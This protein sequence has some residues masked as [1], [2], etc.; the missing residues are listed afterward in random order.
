[1][2]RVYEDYFTPNSKI[3]SRSV[4]IF[5]VFALNTIL[6]LLLTY[7][8]HL[9]GKMSKLMVENLNLL[10]KMHEGLIVVS[11]KDKIVKFAS[12]PAINLLKQMPLTNYT[13][14][15]QRVDMKLDPADLDKPQF[16]LINDTVDT[17]SLK[18]KDEPNHEEISLN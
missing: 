14:D 3:I 10:N 9:R 15:G 17:N 2:P 18:K 16:K 7:I 4:D 11:E 8:A 12:K 13:E 6:S 1:M 5:Y